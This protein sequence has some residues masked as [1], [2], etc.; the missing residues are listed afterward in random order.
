MN[1]HGSKILRYSYL[2]VQ[3]RPTDRRGVMLERGIKPWGEETVFSSTLAAHCR[4][5]EQWGSIVELRQEYYD[6]RNPQAGRR[7]VQLRVPTAICFFYDTPYEQWWNLEAS[8]DLDRTFEV[9]RESPKAYPSFYSGSQPGFDSIKFLWVDLFDADLHDRA[10]GRALS[11][12]VSKFIRGSKALGEIDFNARGLVRVIDG[13][14]VAVIN[15]GAFPSGADGLPNL[16]DGNR[17]MRSLLLTLLAYSR[18]AA[19]ERMD[20]E[21]QHALTDA[22]GIDPGKLNALVDESIRS[23][24]TLF[25]AHPVKPTNNETWELYQALEA[26]YDLTRHYDEATARARQLVDLVRLRRFRSADER[27]QRVEAAALEQTRVQRSIHR[28]LGWTVLLAGSALVA[29]L[30]SL[31]VR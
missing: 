23:L 24:L 4:A 19:L 15:P 14:G 9:N 20:Q 25:D 1:D 8:V 16:C 10:V 28:R 2:A 30:L 17:P 11:A 29:G 7:S 3:A 13:K 6:P 18:L 26:R 21:V 27:A 5:T 31:T 12:G 22:E